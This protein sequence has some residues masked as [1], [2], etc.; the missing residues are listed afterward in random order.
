MGESDRF[1][2]GCH[3]KVFCFS[4]GIDWTFKD[5]EFAVMIGPFFANA[6]LWRGDH[7]KR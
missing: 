4:I 2:Y 6:I 5:V 1:A 3:K 7:G